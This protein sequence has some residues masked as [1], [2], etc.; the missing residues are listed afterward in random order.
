MAV[1]DFTAGSVVSAAV[2]SMVLPAVFMVDASAVG[3]ALGEGSDITDF[4]VTLFTGTTATLTAT[5][6]AT[7]RLGLRSAKCDSSFENHGRVSPR[8]NI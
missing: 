1:G 8:R 3:V 5:T 2:D 4:M 7:I 6:D